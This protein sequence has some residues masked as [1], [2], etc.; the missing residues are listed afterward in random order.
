MSRIHRLPDHLVNKIAAGEVVERPASVVKELVENAIDAGARA[1][2]VELKDAGRQLIRVTD[3]G[4]GMTRGRGRPGA[5]APRHVEARDGR[6]SRGHRDARLPRRGA[7]R[8]LRRHPLRGALIAPRRRVGHGTLVRGEGGVVGEAARGH[9]ARDHRSRRRI[10]SSTRPGG[11]SSS[12]RAPTEL[13]AALRLLEGIGL[14][15]S[16]HPSP[17]HPQ[18]QGRAHRAERA[19]R[20]AIGSARSGASSLAARMLDVDRRAGATSR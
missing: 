8:H 6:R 14:A 1:V 12:R 9:P 15:A 4:I 11:S 19:Q 7:A 17:G 10:S 16:G 18:R 3:D 13:A 20:C 2:T 5:P